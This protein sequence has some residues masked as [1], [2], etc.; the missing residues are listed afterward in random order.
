MIMLLTKCLRLIINEARLIKDMHR[1]RKQTK[2]LWM[3]KNKSMK[4]PH[5]AH[6]DKIDEKKRTIKTI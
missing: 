5:T 6:G 2:E 3:N 1:K 4:A